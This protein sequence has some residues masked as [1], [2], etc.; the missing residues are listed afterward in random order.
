MVVIQD[1]GQ[2]SEKGHYLYE[3]DTAHVPEPSFAYFQAAVALALAG[4]VDALV[5]AP[6]AKEKWLEAG[7]P[8]EGHTPYL[9]AAT[10]ARDHAM[11]FW[12]PS[13]KLLLFTIHLP[14]KEIFSA[15]KK[16]KINHF[17]TFADRELGRLFKH[18]FTFLVSG[19][20]PH[21]GEHGFLGREEIDEI[22]PALNVLQEKI[23]IKGPFPPDTVFMKARHIKDAVVVCW[24]HDQGL[25]PFKLLHLY[26]GVNV[27]LGLP[28]IRTSPDHGT[29]FDIAGQGIANP[30]SMKAAIA[31]AEKLI[32]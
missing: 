2:I 11:F 5:T 4:Q 19:L 28:F 13:L 9:A 12:S 21:A 27:T 23:K 24:Y 17:L 20:N 30:G 8:Y 29:A 16:E 10:K 31:L 22:I 14:L 6:I 26:A 25:I 32:G 3:I 1:I 7:I 18:R 15:I